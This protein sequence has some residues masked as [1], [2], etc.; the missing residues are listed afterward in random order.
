MCGCF[1]LFK[2]ASFNLDWLRRLG[3]ASPKV[4]IV[5]FVVGVLFVAVLVLLNPY[6]P[7]LK[8]NPYPI[9]SGQ[10]WIWWLTN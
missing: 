7:T 10:W 6:A 1:L 8:M 3:V 2:G 5:S 9:G 4:L